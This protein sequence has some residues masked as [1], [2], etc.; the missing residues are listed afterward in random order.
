[1]KL[2]WGSAMGDVV[3]WKGKGKGPQT[4]GVLQERRKNYRLMMITRVPSCGSKLL[5]QFGS[6][7]VAG[8][9]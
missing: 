8:S 4:T 5:A 3:V 6:A 7:D 9:R 2:C 1:M